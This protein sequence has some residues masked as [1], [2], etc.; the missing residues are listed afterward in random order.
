MKTFSINKYL[1]ALLTVTL[2]FVSCVKDDTEPEPEDPVTPVNP[3]PPFFRWKTEP[4]NLVESDSSVC[5]VQSNVIFGYKNGNSHNVEIRLSSMNT[6]TYSTSMGNE[7]D[8]F[9]N[10]KLHTGAGTFV[11]TE[12]TNSTVSGNFTCSLSGG[13][14]TSISGTFA[15][16][17][18]RY[19]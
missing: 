17:P 5:F 10:N 2:F 6:G 8:Y 16:V 18:K 19:N 3:N 4:G 12:S 11:I 9:V 15:S 13:T 14:L 7:L 1:T